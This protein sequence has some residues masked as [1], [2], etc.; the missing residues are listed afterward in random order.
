M[1]KR[2][3][4]TGG[5]GGPGGAVYGLGLLGALGWFWD[6]ADGEGFW[7]HVWAVGESVLWPMFLV[8]RA[9]KGLEG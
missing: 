8:Y 7:G 2:D 6:Q 9:F 5:P 3:R 4:G 1:S